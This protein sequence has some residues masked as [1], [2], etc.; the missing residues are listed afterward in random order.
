MRARRAGRITT[1]GQLRRGQ[2]VAVGIQWAITH[3]NARSEAL[4]IRAIVASE[5]QH[6]VPPARERA[7]PGPPGQGARCRR[8]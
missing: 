5:G 2:N 4:A 6:P 3:R 8:L 1:G 7:Q